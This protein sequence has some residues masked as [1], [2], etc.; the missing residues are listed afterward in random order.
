MALFILWWVVL[1]YGYV[2]ARKPFV[3]KDPE[4]LP[5]AVVIGF[6]VFTSLYIY[7]VGTA[8]ELAENYRYRWVVEPLFFVLAVTGGTHLW[9]GASQVCGCAS[10]RRRRRHDIGT[11]CTEVALLVVVV[12]CL[13]AVIAYFPHLELFAYGAER[14]ELLSL[15]IDRDFA[16]YWLAGHMV[17]AGDALSLFDPQAYLARLQASFGPGLLRS[18]TGAIRRTSCCSCG[19]WDSSLQER[20]VRLS[21]CDLRAVPSCSRRLPAS[22]RTRFRSPDARRGDTRLF[23]GH[24]GCDAERVPARRCDAPGPRV[25]AP[26]ARG[27]W[28]LL[29]RADRQT[30]TRAAAAALAALRSQLARHRVDSGIYGAAGR[31]VGRAVRRRFL[32]RLPDA[33]SRSSADA[34]SVPNGAGFSY[35]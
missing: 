23:A 5:R 32:D 26:R 15:L 34:R 2:Q 30:A 21:G 33:V 19:R 8:F 1:G 7:G 20:A 16:N 29:C 27:G 9:C 31:H 3:T 18:I 6:I 14:S 11:P 24:S 10:R 12:L 35:E 13:I 22:L 17:L 4:S 28:L 25:D